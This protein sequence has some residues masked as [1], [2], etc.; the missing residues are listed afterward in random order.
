MKK[1]L[2][3]ALLTTFAMSSTD[4]NT[5]KVFINQAH[6]YQETMKGDV[7]SKTTLAFYKEKIV[8]HCGNIVA[9]KTYEKNFFAKAMMKDTVVTQEN[10]KMA[11][12]IAKNYKENTEFTSN[13]ILDAY[14]ENIVDNCGTLVAVEKPSYCFAQ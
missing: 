5:C 7:L 2:L 3:M 6:K 4:V 13:I 10:C 12:K 8:A 9:K 1:I 14:K 11:I